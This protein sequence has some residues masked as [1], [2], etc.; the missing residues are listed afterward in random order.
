MLIR[1]YL[2]LEPSVASKRELYAKI[3]KLKNEI[4]DQSLRK[5][6]TKMFGKVLNTSLILFWISNIFINSC[7]KMYLK[8]K[9][10][11]NTVSGNYSTF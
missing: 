8:T 7:E 10:S 6:P 2:H 11:E 9:K 1:I 4:R 3:I 5:A